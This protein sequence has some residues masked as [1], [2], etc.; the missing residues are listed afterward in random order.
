MV[1]E[2]LQ[3]LEIIPHAV[4]VEVRKNEK[5]DELSNKIDVVV[6]T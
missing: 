1:L 2:G 3:I 5:F 6:D 4:L